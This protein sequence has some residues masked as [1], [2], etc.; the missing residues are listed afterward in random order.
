VAAGIAED[1]RV[2]VLEDD[3][4]RGLAPA[5]WAMKAVALFTRLKADALV[6]EVNQGGDMVRA[7]LQQIDPAIPLR[8]VHATRGKWLRAE[9][10]A[11]MYQQGKVKHV[12]PPME[13]LEDEMCDFG[14]SGLSSGGSPDRLDALVWAVTELTARSARREPRVRIL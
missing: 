12:D 1:G 7:V 13:S 11:M 10:V 14:M 2:Y 6:A 4:V 5:G 8:T 9:P 3:S